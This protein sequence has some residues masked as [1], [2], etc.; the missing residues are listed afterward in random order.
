MATLALT[1]TFVNLVATGEAV[2]A[3]TGRPRS[4]QYEMTGQ[5]RTY[6]GGR[7][8]SITSVGEVGKYA[9]RMV[10]VPRT[11]VDLLRDWA[12]QLVQVR[13]HVGRKFVGVYYGISIDELVAESTWNIAID[14]TVVTA[15]EGV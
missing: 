12:G 7:R 8:R 14:L 3:Q 1:K 2:S 5:V 15:D 6:A 11:S 9:F 13:D 10:L 4:E